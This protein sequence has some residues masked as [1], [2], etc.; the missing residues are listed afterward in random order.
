MRAL[1]LLLPLALVQLAAVPEPPP[2]PP[3]AEAVPRL[4]TVYEWLRI[5][6]APRS[7]E[8][9]QP[10][11][12][13]RVAW[14]LHGILTQPFG[15]TGFYREPS[16]TDCPNGFHAGI[17]LADPPG[18]PIRAAAPGLAYPIP[19]VER[20]GNHVVVQ[21]VGGLATN[22]AH[23]SRMNVA[24]GQL[25]QAGDVIGFVGSTGNSTG[26]HLHFEVRYAGVPLD[27]ILYLQGSPPDPFPLPPG[28]PGAQRDDWLGRR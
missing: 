9:F 17:D 2:P 15:C 23:M 11:G 27:P 25:V 7:P 3:P 5:L 21:H 6:P 12:G 20:Y 1:A 28:W 22:Y 19:D 16:Q 14:P 10:P 8:G 26:P 4:L 18:T 13:Q 24:W